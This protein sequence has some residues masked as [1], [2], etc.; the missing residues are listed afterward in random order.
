M[1]TSG[2]RGSMDNL[3]MMAG[4]IGQPKVRGKRRKRVPRQSIGTLPKKCKGSSRERIRRLFFKRALSRQNS[5]C[6]LFLDGVVSRYSGRTAK[7]G[8]AK[9]IDQC[10][11]RPQSG[12]RWN[13]LCQHTA[14]RIIQ[15]DTA[16][17]ES[18]QL[19]REKAI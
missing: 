14:N 12:R 9:E 17:M 5:S 1:A 2:A 7:S 8:Y 11:G 3:A 6:F 15:F 16:K 19:E 10:H 18:T 13:G 4:S